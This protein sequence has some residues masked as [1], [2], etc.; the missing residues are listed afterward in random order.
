M[1]LLDEATS[2]VDY[3]SDQVIQ[4][5]IR[6]EIRRRKCTVLSIAH[7]LD[8]ILDADRIVVMDRGKVVEFDSPRKLESNKQSLL[9]QLI[10]AENERDNK[11]DAKAESKV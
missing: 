6:E 2:S 10:L 3:R 7:R 5:T 1:L 9:S 11:I 8:T 4:R